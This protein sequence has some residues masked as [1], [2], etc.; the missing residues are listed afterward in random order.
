MV[1]PGPGGA[2]ESTR[3]RM[4]WQSA[5]L[6]DRG[7]RRDRNED[8]VLERPHIFAVADGM[9]GHAAGDV[10]SRL[11][12]D[13]LAAAFPAADAVDP[14][15]DALVAHLEATLVA[16][17]AAILG[18]AEDHPF[19]AGMGTTLTAL[20]PLPASAQCVI[21]HIGD[22]RAYRVRD[23]DLEQLTHDHTWVQE[24]VDAGML[25]TRAARHHRLSSVLNR[26]LGTPDAGPVDTLVLDTR[27]ADLY[28]LCSD[29]LTSMLEDADLHLMLVRDV[30]LMQHAR[31]LVD[32]ANLRGGTDNISVVL[33]RPGAA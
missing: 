19:C 26:V 32:A 23:G 18:H 22:S 28:L 16:A 29:G 5:A 15:A 2:P 11:A 14:A 10:A 8:A 21:A 27:P 4:H 1:V 33:L 24:Q 20:V 12:I 6:S 13:V 30:P 7:R 9:G 17:N 31:D 3:R 25:T